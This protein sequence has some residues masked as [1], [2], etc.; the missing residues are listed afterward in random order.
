MCEFFSFSVTGLKLD[1]YARHGFANH[2]I[3]W[4]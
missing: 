4:H 3:A 1:S 2:D